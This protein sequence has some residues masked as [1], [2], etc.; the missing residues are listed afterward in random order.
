MNCSTANIPCRYDNIPLKKGPKGT[1][2]HVL[3]RLRG[4]HQRNLPPD[5]G[6]HD[7]TLSSTFPRTQGFLPAGLVDSCLDFFFDNVYPFMP[8]IH[9]QKA[10]EAA[11]NMERSTEA[12]CLIVALCAYVM[13]QTNMKVPPNMLSRPEIAQASNITP[14]HDLLEESVRVRNGCDYREN[15][16]QITVLTSW[17][18]CRSYFG[19]AQENTAWGYLREAA[20]QVQLL[21]MHDEKTYKHDSSDSSCKRVLY[22]LLFMAERYATPIA[23]GNI[24][25][26]DMAD[27]QTG[28]THF[29]STT[30]CPFIQP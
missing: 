29:T 5:L 4:N 16:T 8:V 11:I 1:R 10:Q 9:R 20:T 12:Y 27:L 26:L 14:G 24:A 15:P 22:W 7:R 13:I 2:G 19:L 6:F 3:L 30:Q 21:G 23:Q 28:H 17:F 18:Y 25:R